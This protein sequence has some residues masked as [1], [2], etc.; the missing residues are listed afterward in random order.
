[1]Q[2]K[3]TENIVKISPEEMDRRLNECYD[4]LHQRSLELCMEHDS[5]MVCTEMVFA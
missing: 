3:K 2:K 5:Q 4:S 1:M